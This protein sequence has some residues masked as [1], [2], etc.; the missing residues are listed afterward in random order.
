MLSGP[1][2]RGRHKEQG[3]GMQRQGGGGGAGG[4]YERRGRGRKGGLEGLESFMVSGSQPSSA[5]SL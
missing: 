5:V 3:E 1:L 2:Q 4:G